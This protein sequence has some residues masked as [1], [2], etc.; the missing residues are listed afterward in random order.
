MC[1]KPLLTFR[2]LV[3]T[4]SYSNFV[5]LLQ[6]GSTFITHGHVLHAD[7]AKIWQLTILKIPRVKWR[8]RFYMDSGFIFTEVLR[9][10]R[11]EPHHSKE[12]HPR[13]GDRMEWYA[14]KPSTVGVGEAG[15]RP[16]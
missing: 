5:L 16:L 7:L 1:H 14:V 15:H 9:H 10:G 6:L 8:I 2:P 11:L 3:I 13:D 4:Y 12:G